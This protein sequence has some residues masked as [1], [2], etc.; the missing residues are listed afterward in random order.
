MFTLPKEIKQKWLDAL[1]SGHYAKG[2]GQ[3][4]DNGTYCC[5][6]VLQ[7][8][9]DGKCEHTSIPTDTWAKSKGLNPTEKDCWSPTVIF[10]NSSMGLWELN[11]VKRLSFTAIADIIEAQCEGV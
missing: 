10:K 4:E 8:C 1:R 3:L 5:L 6:G 9:W 11:D 7:H 2:C